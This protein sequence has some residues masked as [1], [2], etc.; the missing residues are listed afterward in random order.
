[1]KTLFF[2]AEIRHISIPLLKSQTLIARAILSIDKTNAFC[3][4]MIKW[5]ETGGYL[6][7]S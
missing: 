3:Q 7:V 5:R 4:C 2:M 6:Q 1:M